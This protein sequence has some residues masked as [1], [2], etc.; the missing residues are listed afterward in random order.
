MDTIKTL[1]SDIGAF[2]QRLWRRVKNLF[3]RRNGA[4]STADHINTAYPSEHNTLHVSET[5]L[6][7]REEMDA[8]LKERRAKEHPDDEPIFTEKIRRR[9]YILS[10]LFTSIRFL[11]LG[12]VLLGLVGL[13]AV[14]GVA[15]AY[16]ETAPTIDQ[17]Q[18]TKSARTSFIYDKDGE[19][20]TTIAYVEYR[21]WVDIQDIPA[22][23]QNAFISVEDVRFYL[24]SG[25]DFKRLFSAALE[26]LG[27][28]NASG[29]STITQQ[30]IKNKIL[31]SERTYKRK[32]QEAYLSLE[33]ED[34]LG[35]DMILEAYLNDIHLG[36]SNYG[37]KTAAL[38]YFGKELD[39]LTIRECAM[40]AG[41]TQNPYRYNP[42]K[43]KY[44]RD[45]VYWE[46]TT[47]R[48]DRVLSNM[49]QAG[50]I[51]LS[52]YNAALTEEVYIVP[53]S[54]QKKLN[55]MPHFVEYAIRD[56]VE[57]L[58]VQRGL[59]ATS[60]NLSALEN[61][62]RTGGYHIYTTVDTAM[63]HMVQ[64][65]LSTWDDYPTLSDPTKDI[66]LE[67][68]SNGDILE[69]KQ[70]Q[71]SAVVFDYHTGELRAIIGSRDEP[72]IS[73][74]WNRAR[75]SYV[76][77]GSSIKPLAVYG[78]ALDAGAS[79]GT[80]LANFEWSIDGW[81]SDKGYPSIGDTDHIGPVTIRRGIV[82]SLNVV[83]AR[84]LMEWV[85]PEVGAQYLVNLGA[86]PSKINADGS[87]L[88]LGTSGLTTIQMAAAYGAIGA[89]GEYKEPLSF[90]RV[91]DSSG[92]VILNAEDVRTVRQVYQPST[93][94]MLVDM[95]TNAVNS[96]TGTNAKINGITVAGKTGTNANY[97]SV[98]FAG[99][100]P[101]YSASIWIGHD[102][103]QKYPL[104]SKTT[105]GGKAAPLWSAF[106]TTI[107][108][109]LSDRPIIDATPEELGLVKMSL[110]AVSGLLPTDAC[111]A[112][113]N[114][115]VPV[116][117]WV[118]SANVPVETCNMHVATAICSETHQIATE[119]CPYTSQT[120][121]AI[122]IIT[123]DSYYS[124]ISDE[125]LQKGFRNFVRTP[126]TFEE[127]LIYG[128]SGTRCTVH[129]S[130]GNIGAARDDP[131]GLN[132]QWQAAYLRDEIIEYMNR[133]SLP[134][135]THNM[136][137]EHVIILND[138]VRESD[139]S[140]IQSAVA[141]AQQAYS[142]MRG[143]YGA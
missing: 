59:P 127:Y 19:L 136:L 129:S 44:Q 46:Y 7:D 86:D 93:A 83:A 142:N 132:W 123:P 135:A 56:V 89:G 53:E 69:V 98:Y 64:E 60:A 131:A 14:M 104:K 10:L 48:T 26:V 125:V 25:V 45:S 18:L 70:P 76:A 65:T 112:D 117:D 88:A 140:L 5:R 16:V 49:Y 75:Q 17:A 20:I 27:N 139:T 128:V 74:S 35:K 37:V 107:H 92:N 103:P 101:Y 38:D 2:F 102:N 105:G 24:H 134:A 87:G 118:Y 41:L 113:T 43:N 28:Q 78:P 29:G 108:E 47:E 32:I 85:T 91:M 97:E 30:L 63:Q 31:G 54:E 62:L 115:Y 61:E 109:G 124:A 133:K 73:K 50:S 55:D 141:A 138:M 130:G 51:T 77:V 120:A 57:H 106:M 84:T 15:K 116:N 126:Y 114:G 79:P 111:A 4:P 39:E 110:C 96:G 99:L 100:T 71:A 95:L 13:G 9:P 94:Y 34:D 81:I 3:T 121:G 12:A 52:E 122:V 72:T 36:E 90:T 21:D 80:V 137:R 6:F 143:T 22:T 11:F 1:F 8:R 23:L 82:S 58:L 66:R 67:T 68:L 40:L 33:L 119:D 42:R